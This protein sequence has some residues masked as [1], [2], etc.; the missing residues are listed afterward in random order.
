MRSALTIPTLLLLALLA[1]STALAQET[2]EDA[3]TEPV[4][5][6]A[7]QIEELRLRTEQDPSDAEA[8]TR[9]G[10][11]YIEEELFLDARDAF[12]YALQAAPGEPLSH[13]NLGLALVRMERWQECQLPLSTF[14][15]MAPDDV[16]GHLLLGQAYAESGDIAR[17]RTTWVAGADTPSMPPAD[18]VVLL[19]ELVHSVVE[20]GEGDPTDADLRGLAATIE[21]RRELLATDEGAVLRENVDYCWLELARRAKEAGDDEAAIAAWAHL[22]EFGTD[23]NTP[24]TQPIELLLDAGRNEDAAALV[25]EAV[26]RRPGDALT[27]YLQGRVAERTGD[28]RGAADAYSQ[29]ARLDDAFPGVYPALGGVLAQLGD[30]RGASAALAKAVERGE[31]GA[32]AAYNMGV[33]LS[34]KKQYSAAIPHLRQAIE[35]EPTLKDAYRALGTAYRKTDQ[36]TKSAQTYQDIVDRFGPDASDLYQLA[37]AQAKTNRHRDAAQNY[38]M[39]VALE[40]ANRNAHYG[41]GNSLLKIDQFE[42]AS[43]AFSRALEL[44]PDF[45]AASYNLALCYQKMRSFEKAIERYELTLEL[46]ETY[47]IYVNMAICY[48]ELGDEETSDEYY[49]LANE[50]KTGNR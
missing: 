23:E 13:L 50:F 47:A 24:Y 9:L 49:G 19:R 41:L 25:E 39:V 35:A 38:S 12:V 44:K 22:R 1:F 27:H 10:I 29:T 34:Q 7:L 36:F 28:L 18:Q 21:A 8:W 43:E 33:V 37:F 48:K 26:S 30:T 2:V 5:D 40:P 16:R 31:G 14:R 6:S 11:L 45:Y 20:G 15:T 32:A 3:A 46:R 17:A 4:V 42:R